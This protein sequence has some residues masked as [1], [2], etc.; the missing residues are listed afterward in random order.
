[1]G[2]LD[3]MFKIGSL[4]DWGTPLVNA[5]RAISGDWQ[6]VEVDSLDEAIA[7]NSNGGKGIDITNDGRFYVMMPR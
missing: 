6:A 5:G 3:T 2:L 1:M 4:L 7:L